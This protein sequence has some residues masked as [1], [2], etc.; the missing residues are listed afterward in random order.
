[1]LSALLYL[2]YHSLKNRVLLRLRRLKQPKYLVGGIVGAL[3][4][5]FYFFRYLF[6]LPGTRRGLSI[7]PSPENSSLYEALGAAMF[8]VAVLLA[9]ILPHGRAALAFSEAEVAFLFPAPISRG[10]LRHF[11]LMRSQS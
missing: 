2:Q 5:Y 7:D 6:H 1:M 3:Y 9:W 11:L 8:L 10:G 4:F